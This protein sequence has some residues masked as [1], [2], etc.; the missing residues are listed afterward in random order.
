MATKATHLAEA[1]A[2]KGRDFSPKWD[3]HETWDTNQFLRQFHSAM[4][5]NLNPKLSIGW[6]DKDVPKKIFLLLR[7]PKTIVAA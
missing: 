6:D 7:K 1:R 4:A 2:K 3:G 5:K